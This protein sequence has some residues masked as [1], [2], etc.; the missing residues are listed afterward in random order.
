MESAPHGQVGYKVDNFARRTSW[1]RLAPQHRGSRVLENPNGKERRSW[2][3]FSIQVEVLCRETQDNEAL[4]WPAQVVDI[5]RSGLQ[6][7]SSHKFEPTTVIRIGK[8]DGAQELSQFLEALVI[9]VRRSPEE[10]WTLG[11]SFFRQL[12]EAELLGWIN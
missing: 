7:L 9:R 2:K 10:K 12:D 6:L 3:R 8:R 1:S 11:C 5:S 4:S